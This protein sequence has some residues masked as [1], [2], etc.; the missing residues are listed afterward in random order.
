MPNTVIQLK[1]SATPSAAPT[2]LANGELA[3]NYA[4]GKL[5]YKA[6]NGTIASIQGSGGGTNSFGTV[7]ANNTLVV[8]DSPGSILT[9]VPGNNISIVGDAINDKVTVGLKDDVAVS[10]LLSVTAASGDEGGEIRLANAI[11][12]SLL[13]GPVNIDIYQNKIRFFVSG[14]DARGAFIN[15][16]ATTAGVGTDLLVTAT[17]TDN[18]ARSTASQ[19]FDKANAALPNVSGVSF[20][21]NLTVSQNLS[22]DR[23]F[24]TNNGNGENFKVGDDA[25]IGDTNLANA[26][27]IKGQQNASIGYVMFGPNDGKLLGRAGTDN[28]TYDG[29]IIWHAG[30]YGASSGLD[31]DLLDGQ[32]GS[33]YGIASDVTAAFG[34]ANTAN[35]TADLAFNQANAAFTRANTVGTAINDTVSS[36]RYI[37]FSNAISGIVTPNVSAGLT[38]NPSSNTLTIN[39][40]LNAIT[41]SF[42]IKHPTKENMHLRYGSLEGPENGI[43]VRGKLRNETVIRLPDYW[44]SLIDP[45][46]ITVHLTPYGLKQDLWIKSKSETHITVNQPAYCYYI[47]YAERKDV[48]KLIVEY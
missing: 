4:D 20:N 13:A 45:E 2:N 26:F 19:A 21:G 9:V 43:Y 6:A 48:E 3:I 41:K 34:R 27:R 30:N 8:A 16:A 36:T 15:L 18:L 24:S 28:L 40:P 39:G 17:T 22:A 47:V 1:K 44:S 14:G 10:G 11:T 29:N 12:N 38:F 31:A 42:V 37:T 25:W 33:Y 32:Q 35:I 23:I 46:T 7:N 5:F